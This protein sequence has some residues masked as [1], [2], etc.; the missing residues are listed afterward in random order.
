MLLQDAQNRFKPSSLSDDVFTSFL[1]GSQKTDI[2]AYT[3]SHPQG[4]NDRVCGASLWEKFIDSGFYYP[5]PSEAKSLTNAA[6]YIRVN[7]E[8]KAVRIL[9]LGPGP[10]PSVKSKTIGFLQVIDRLESYTCIDLCKTYLESTAS[11]ISQAIPSVLVKKYAFDFMRDFS[12]LRTVMNQQK[13]DV[14]LLLGNTIANLADSSD[15]TGFAA[16]RYLKKLKN[17]MPENACLLIGQDGCTES[18]HIINA[19]SHPL[20]A[21]HTL[22]I[23]HRIKRDLAIRS[24]DSDAFSFHVKWRPAQ[25]R[26]TASA[27]SLR[28]QSFKV[29]GREIKIE[30]DQLLPISTS[31]KY[32]PQYFAKLLKWA[33]FHE[34]KSYT[35]PLLKG[36]VHVAKI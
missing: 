24:F 23:M 33:G 10:I 20:F 31:F 22:N 15:G 35:D 1:S 34:V 13:P 32:P 6:R 14:V 2:D 25:Y 5:I 4:L 9:E 26:L 12:D 19:Y 18:Q 29:G 11:T 30:Q 8:Q 36:T 16:L 28:N 7:I 3:Y 27:R 21:K 17:L